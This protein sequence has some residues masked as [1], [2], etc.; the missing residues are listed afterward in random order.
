M[1]TNY[2]RQRYMSFLATIF[3]IILFVSCSSKQAINTPSKTKKPPTPIRTITSTKIPTTTITPTAEFTLT[4]SPIPTTSE[5][6]TIKTFSS[7]IC[8]DASYIL[9]SNISPDGEWISS[10]CIG[11]LESPNSYLELTNIDKANDW[12]VYYNNF[13]KDTLYDHKDIIVPYHWSKD[14]R[15]LYAVA[16][17]RLSGCCWVGSRFTLLIRVNLET[18]EQLEILNATDLNLAF[19]FDFIISESERYLYFT[20]PTNQPY[21]FAIL[22]LSTWDTR[23][24][25]I[26][27]PMSMDLY[28]GKISPDETKL[29]VPLFKYYEERFELKL[30]SIALID[31]ETNE[32][33]LLISG[34][35]PEKEFY[36]V[37]WLD[38][39]RVLLYDSDPWYW[40]HPTFQDSVG[41]WI[42][43]T[44]TGELTR[45]E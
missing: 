39:N 7:S 32:Q 16:R 37:H 17:T 10:E 8:V 9:S 31:L 18:G 29:I 30:D 20:P 5:Q 36:P 22:D 28:L 14:G 26:E 11:S 42:L 13:S 45:S 24:I 3:I 44:N 41:H 15:F 12:K 43:D 6:A 1:A 38:D 25:I 23:T 4:P 35:S 33:K 21:S 19:P 27:F 34:L 40:D 2:V